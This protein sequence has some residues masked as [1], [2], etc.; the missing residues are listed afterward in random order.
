[1]KNKQPFIIAVQ[2]G[3]IETVKNLLATNKTL[4]SQIDRAVV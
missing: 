2:D 4:A 3:D 1:M